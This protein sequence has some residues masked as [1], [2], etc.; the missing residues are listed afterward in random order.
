MILCG[1]ERYGS[2]D[3]SG[4]V[5]ENRGGFTQRL[6]KGIVVQLNQSSPAQI[7]VQTKPSKGRVTA[8]VA[9]PSPLIRAG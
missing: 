4:R 9:M 3:W 6:R 2:D 7:T 8:S 5:A 1:D